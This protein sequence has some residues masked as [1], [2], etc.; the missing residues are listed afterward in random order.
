MKALTSMIEPTSE[1][2]RGRKKAQK[3]PKPVKYMDADGN[4]VK[5]GTEQHYR[6]RVG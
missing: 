4:P 2:V 5:E 6:A 1:D 3:G